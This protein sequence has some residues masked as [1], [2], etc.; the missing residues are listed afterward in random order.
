MRTGIGSSLLAVLVA[1]GCGA[2]LA[3]LE[4]PRQKLW[5]DPDVCPACTHNSD[6]GFTYY[7]C[8][9]TSFSGAGSAT[10]ST[11]TEYDPCVL[12]GTAIWIPDSPTCCVSGSQTGAVSYFIRVNQA[13]FYFD[14]GATSSPPYA[15]TTTVNC[16]QDLIFAWRMDVLHK[17]DGQSACTVCNANPTTQW[18]GISYWRCGG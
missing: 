17:W 8:L 9:G 16:V 6:V 14:A 3:F 2:A 4:P 18:V 15:Y 10:C 11:Q 12:S 13:I 7:Q 5:A 1:F